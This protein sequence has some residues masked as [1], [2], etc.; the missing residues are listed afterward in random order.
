MKIDLQGAY[1]IQV[2]E[3]NELV[4]DSGEF[5]NLITDQA[6]ETGNPFS[7]GYLA[8]GLKTDP[9]GPPPT[10]NDTRLHNEVSQVNVAFDPEAELVL[11]GGVRYAR[12]KVVG[13][14]TGLSG[15]IAE[16]GFKRDSTEN[17]AVSRSLVRDAN[18]HVTVIPVEPIQT[19]SLTYCVYIKV[20]AVLD[21]QQITT[22]FGTAVLTMKTSP[23][24]SK[25]QGVLSGDFSQP[26]NDNSPGA[27]ALE[28]SDGAVQ[29][30]AAITS[31]YNP[32]SGVSDFTV[33]FPAMSVN[34]FAS[35]IKGTA[36]SDN[37]PVIVIDPPLL[38]P[39]DNDFTLR[40]KFEWSSD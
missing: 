3:G 5:S 30:S 27:L 10:K 21:V 2:Y 11:V 9:S 28:L 25:P 14:F 38:V 33:N 17:T 20:P 35:M 24:L 32:E 34:R 8:V 1:R 31:V 23:M 36:D 26:F 15:E 19:I 7:T 37:T 4:S 12:K 40:L 22:S 16:L 18:G 13:S 39:A 29:T 6:L